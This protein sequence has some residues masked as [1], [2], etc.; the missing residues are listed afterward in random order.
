MFT[1]ML[2]CRSHSGIIDENGNRYASWTYDAQGRGLISQMGSGANLTT[3]SSDDTTGN[4]TVTN[5][6]GQ[7]ETFLFT[8]LQYIAPKGA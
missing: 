7:Q 8:T 1:K 4:R 3:I 6:L 5:A 2:L